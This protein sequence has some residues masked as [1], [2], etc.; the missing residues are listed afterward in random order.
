MRHVRWLTEA[1]GL[2]DPTGAMWCSRDGDA[3]RY[4]EWRLSRR[5]SSSCATALA[6]P[7]HP[8]LIATA[9]AAIPLL[10]LSRRSRRQARD[11]AGALQ[12]R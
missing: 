10:I 11:R 1:V 4:V 5:R 9:L 7:A 8:T 12:A 2:E 3:G 6:S